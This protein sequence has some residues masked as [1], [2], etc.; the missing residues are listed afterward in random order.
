MTHRAIDSLALELEM[1]RMYIAPRAPVYDRLLRMLEDAVT[2]EV[3]ERLAAAWAGR[4]FRGFYER[5]LLLLAGLRD[6]VLEEGPSHPL[7]LAIGPDRA[8][9]AALSTERLAASLAPERGLWGKVAENALQ[10]NETSRAVAWLWPAHLASTRPL[11]LFDVG[12]SAGLNLVADALPRPWIRSD[13]APLVVDPLP[14]IV[15]RTGFD[16][17]PLDV[18]REEDARWLRACVWPGQGH[19]EA[20][21]AEAIAAYRARAGRPD[22]PELVTAE[23]AEVPDRLPTLDG[24]GPRGLAL[25]T[26]VR[27]YL[28]EEEDARYEAGM[29][30]WLARC[31]PGMGVWV[32]LEVAIAVPPSRIRAHVQTD[33]G[34]RTLDLA[35]CEPHPV[36]IDVDEPAVALFRRATGF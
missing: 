3:A 12:T 28:S 20:R 21:L 26:V 24:T 29:R 7:Y 8:D 17:H 33:A 19:R 36:E 18:T 9:P 25:Q 22:G 35:G 34:L 14:P 27:D 23:A 6:D 30:A 1:Q 5:P 32:E 11:A 16:L 31:A 10:T 13:G 15:A 4:R 2:G